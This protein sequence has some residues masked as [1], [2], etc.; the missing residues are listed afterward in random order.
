[1]ENYRSLA[2]KKV[3]TFILLELDPE[4]QALSE[5]DKRLVGK[6]RANDF[7]GVAEDGKI[8]LLLSQASSKDLDFILPRFEGFNIEV[9]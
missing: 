2:E 8:R 9:K 1:M 5:I 7:I 4:G 3:S 6:V